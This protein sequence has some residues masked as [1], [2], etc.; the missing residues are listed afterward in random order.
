MS[1]M[2]VT[3]SGLERS[4]LPVHDAVSVG[5]AVRYVG[6]YS[7]HVNG[8]R[9]PNNLYGVISTKPKVSL[10]KYILTWLRARVQLCSSCCSKHQ[11]YRHSTLWNSRTRQAVST[12]HKQ[13][14]G[15]QKCAILAPHQ[16]TPQTSQ[17][18]NC[19]LEKPIDEMLVKNFNRDL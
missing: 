9:S 19:S 18:N 15:L 1:G 6:Q 2:Q 14:G 3:A 13:V 17:V 16:T 11:G 8:T 12:S 5:Q 7:L 4:F 10:R